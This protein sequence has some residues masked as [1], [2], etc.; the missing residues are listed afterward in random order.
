MKSLISVSEEGDIEVID[1]F[2]CGN[3]KTQTKELKDLITLCK[4]TNPSNR[5]P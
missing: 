5:V 4:T 3:Q 1:R 2:L